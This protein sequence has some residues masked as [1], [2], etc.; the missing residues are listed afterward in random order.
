M[1]AC[2]PIYATATSLLTF[3]VVGLGAAPAQAQSTEDRAAPIDPAANTPAGSASLPEAFPALAPPVR[4][5][6][7]I[8]ETVDLP[9]RPRPLHG[10]SLTSGISLPLA[11]SSTGGS[12]EG[13]RNA[14]GTVVTLTVRYTPKEGW[15]ALTTLSAYLKPSQRKPWNGDFVYAFGYDN[16]RPNTVSITYTNYGNNRFDP[17]S[18]E[19]FTN[20]LRGSVNLGYK[21][22]LSSKLAEPFL[23]DRQ[24]TIGCRGNSQYSARY[25]RVSGRNGH[26]KLWTSA[27]CR[28]PIWRRA[29]ADLTL[30]QYWRG[31][32]RP[33]DP[34]YT[35][36]F[37]WFDWRPGRVSVQYSNY[38]GMRFPWRKQ[39]VG[40]GKFRN[41]TISA[42]L[43]HAF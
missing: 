37:G 4:V 5:E 41:G 36:G 23:I 26:H 28:Y 39:P 25:E 35:Y 19:G 27:G 3:A 33:W 42:T 32:Q 9:T 2:R 7:N 34:D 15:F 22:N 40:T 11:L 20:F 38:S 1:P 12:S 31:E 17:R 16:W 13:T 30:H 8:D 14:S 21:I 24:Q 29:Y 6:D 10:W 43:T 18:G